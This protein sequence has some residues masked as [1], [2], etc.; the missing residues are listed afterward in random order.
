M[1]KRKIVIFDFDGTL[2]DSFPWFVGRLNQVARLF[3]FNEVR[4]EDIPKLRLMKTAEILDYLN[5]APY[6]L[7]LVIYYFKRLMKRESTLVSLFPQTKELL[8]A[9]QKNGVGIF[10]LSSNSEQNV[11]KILG[12]SSHL[13]DAFYCGAGLKSKD[14]HF[15]KIL[16]Q[17]PS[18]H[19]ISVGD[20]TRDYDAATKW[21]IPHLN[22]TWGYA[23]KEV[24][25][26]LETVESFKELEVRIL[27]Y[28]DIKS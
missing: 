18:K 10:I 24:F 12:P 8:E 3:R 28:F 5:I 11:K 16:K 15:K 1:E 17:Y 9:L 23:S 14:R 2:A 4:E 26:G 6:K 21:D 27:R 13:V 22:V 7:P 25:A 20:E 19:F